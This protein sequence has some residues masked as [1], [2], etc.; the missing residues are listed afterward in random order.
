MYRTSQSSFKELIWERPYWTGRM[1]G[2]RR[3][4][5]WTEIFVTAYLVEPDWQE[6]E[7][8]GAADG[9]EE[10]PPVISDGEQDGGDLDAEEDATYRRPE[11]AGHADGHGRRQHLA[12]PRLVSV[13]ALKLELLKIC[14]VKPD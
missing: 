3:R 5:F 14:S 4:I 7:H 10:P 2:I 12:L 6:T 11:A 9:G 13:N 8:G 1:Q